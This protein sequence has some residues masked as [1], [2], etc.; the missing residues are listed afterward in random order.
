MNVNGFQ[1]TPLAKETTE[2]EKQEKDARART[3]IRRMRRGN[4]KLNSSD[5][6]SLHD[7]LQCFNGPISREQAWALCHQTVKSLSRLPYNEIREITEFSQIILHKDGHIML[8][9]QQGTNFTKSLNS[10]FL[11]LEI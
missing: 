2:M 9:L 3:K 11:Y 6:L 5:G 8:D 7:I 10:S 1:E 4:C